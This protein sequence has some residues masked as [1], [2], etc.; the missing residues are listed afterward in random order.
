MVNVDA[1]SYSSASP[2]RGEMPV[3]MFSRLTESKRETSLRLRIIGWV[4]IIYGV[5]TVLLGLEA[6]AVALTLGRSLPVTFSA[7]MLAFIFLSSLTLGSACAYAGLMLL[8]R[9]R[10]AGF[11]ILVISASSFSSVFLRKPFSIPALVLEIVGLVLIL[12]VWHELEGPLPFGLK[13]ERGV[14]TSLVLV[15]VLG[16]FR[17]PASSRSMEKRRPPTYHPPTTVIRAPRAQ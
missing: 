17:H 4:Y 8:D 3:R 13:S 1:N 12:S 15:F 2:S 10:M 7:L 16:L 6:V 14:V 9:S 5:M 11:L